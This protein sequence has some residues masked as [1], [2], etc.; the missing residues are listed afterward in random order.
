MEEV[1]SLTT[2]LGKFWDAYH[3]VA[4]HMRRRYQG[5]V[6]QPMQELVAQPGAEKL[7]APTWKWE[8]RSQTSWEYHS[9]P[10]IP[11]P[12]LEPQGAAGRRRS[13]S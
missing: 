2:F 6:H 10:F 4:G 11:P 13:T 1:M 8:T 5:C 12:R 3:W 9:G 7:A